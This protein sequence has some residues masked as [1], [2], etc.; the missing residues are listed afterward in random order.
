MERPKTLS[1]AFVKTVKEPGRYGDGRGGFGLSL[2]VKPMTSTGRLSKTFAQRLR[3]DGQIVNIGIGSFP[4][5]S[6]AEARAAAFEN[7]RTLARAST[8]ETLPRVCRPS[9]RL[10]IR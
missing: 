7:R 9:R 2:L 5:V 3:I 6:L 10:P 4:V 8:L 1:A